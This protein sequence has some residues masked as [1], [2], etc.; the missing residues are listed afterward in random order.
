MN[1][2]NPSTV[3]F[4]S[5]GCKINTTGRTNRVAPSL[6]LSKVTGRKRVLAIAAPSITPGAT[7]GVIRD[8]IAA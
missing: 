5:C 8:R 4:R 2:L 6:M 3:R 1:V 7:G